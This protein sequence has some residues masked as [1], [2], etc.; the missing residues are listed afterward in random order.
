MSRI[1]Q[2]SQKR[3]TRE[4]ASRDR[5]GRYVRDLIW[6][7]VRSFVRRHWKM[8]LILLFYP[9]AIALILSL[10]MRG[11]ERWLFIGAVGISGPW[12]VVILII[13]WSGVASQLMGLEGESY[14]ADVL[15]KFRHAGWVLVNGIVIKSGDIDHVVIGP[16]GVLV[17]ESKWS[18][19]MWPAGKDE[20]SFMADRL[21]RAIS[22][23][24]QNRSDVE[25]RFGKSLQGARVRA[26]C[27]LWSSQDTSMNPDWFEVGDV[28]VIRG[29]ALESWLK[30]LTEVTLDQ[31]G[32]ER[33]HKA[34][35]RQA[36]NR[37]ELVQAKSGAPRRTLNKYIAH[38][39][40]A[41]F[42]GF[43]S[44]LAVIAVTS[45]VGA[46]WT[47][48]ATLLFVFIGF[49]A[50][51]FAGLRQFALGWIGTCLALSLWFLV[52]MIRALVG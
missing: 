40:V 52:L 13:L 34:I 8:L 50:R 18:H 33:I 27:V 9:L 23:A 4:L 31:Q 26:I 32:I 22:Q 36:S 16:A 15:R 37:D 35:E 29:A 47:I 3:R 1:S 38:Y 24:R 12:M 28:T 43:V 2:I 14:T 25:W 48:G 44:A 5:V 21:S 49:V 19:D 46:L 30:N 41:P 6:K 39:I 10:F 11:A 7:A 42:M 45:R 20:R 51:Q 17:I